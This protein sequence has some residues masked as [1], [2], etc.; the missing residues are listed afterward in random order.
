MHNSIKTVIVEA[1]SE[2]QGTSIPEEA[3]LD[4]AL[5]VSPVASIAEEVLDVPTAFGNFF[6]Q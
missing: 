4:P 1:N 2:L 5:E 3:T 6:I